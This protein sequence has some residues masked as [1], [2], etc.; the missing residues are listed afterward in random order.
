MN[1]FHVATG[2]VSLSLGHLAYFI[3][4]GFQGLG[5]RCVRSSHFFA[6]SS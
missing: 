4:R 5:H 6:L 1:H 3:E 2:T